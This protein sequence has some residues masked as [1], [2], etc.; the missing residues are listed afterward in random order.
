MFK[1]FSCFKLTKQR[2]HDGAMSVTLTV[3][4]FIDLLPAGKCSLQW[5]V[6]YP[7]VSE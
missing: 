1:R 7:R 5:F 2:I 6:V 3:T 4:T